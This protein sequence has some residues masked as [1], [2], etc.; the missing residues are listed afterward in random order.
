MKCETKTKEQLDEQFRFNAIDENDRIYL[1]DLL[2]RQGSSLTILSGE[3]I[4]WAKGKPHFNATRFILSNGQV[5]TVFHVKP[6]YYY[7]SWNTVRP[8]SEITSYHGNRRITLKEGWENKIHFGYLSWLVKRCQLIGGG[9]SYDPSKIP[10]FLNTDSTFY[11]NPNVEITSVDGRS[12]N[13]DVAWATARNATDGSGADD[14]EASRF[15]RAI[16]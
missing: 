5:S 9:V 1:E 11:P 2:R 10:L 15:F 12:N 4:G 13:S 6:V 16:I 7:T 3:S 8:L 14:V